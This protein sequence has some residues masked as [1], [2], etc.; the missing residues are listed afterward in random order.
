MGL[1]V[2]Y[3]LVNLISITL[4]MVMLLRDFGLYGTVFMIVFFCNRCYGNAVENWA[5]WYNMTL[6]IYS[7]RFSRHF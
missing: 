6:F 4:I 7:F 3:H 5:V 1:F 2:R